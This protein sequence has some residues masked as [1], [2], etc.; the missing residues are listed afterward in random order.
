MPADTSRRGRAAKRSLVG[1]LAALALTGCTPAPAPSPTPSESTTPVR[2]FTVTTTERPATY[3]PAS[4]TTA[5]DALVAH[6]AFSRLMIVHA[7]PGELK[8]DLATDCLY[9]SATVYQCE[10]PKGLVFHN[11]HALTASDVKFSIERAYRLG[12]AGT[13]VSLLDSLQRVEVVD[14]QVVR[15]TLRW[16]DSQFG[17]ALASAAASIVDEEIY[18]PD[19]VRPN[20]AQT[21]GSGPYRLVTTADDQLVFERFDDYVGA[22]TATIDRVRL[23]FAADSAEVEALMAAESTDVV[24]RSLT[25]AAHERLAAETTATAD[26]LTKGGF[27]RQQLPAVR[28]QRLLWHPGS[29]ARDSAELRQVVALALQADRTMTSLI[30]SITTGAVDAFPTGGQPEVPQLGGQRLKLTLAYESRAPGQADLARLV[31]DRIESQAGV[32]VQLLPD[33][34]D[35][36]LFLSDRPAWVNTPFGWLQPY[37]DNALPG[38]ADKIAD[39]VRRARETTDADQRVA[40]LGEI[41]QQAAA[42]LTVLPIAQGAESLYLGRGVTLQGDPFGPGYQ[43]GLWSF[44]R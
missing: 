43:L 38:S 5:A 8:P 20:D 22:D 36:D 37:T 40:L 27:L 39:L 42:D 29:A 25:A 13:S 24:W 14:D 23:G 33:A 12:V 26:G 41:Q 31:R 34:P 4:A 7:A 30:P 17:Y 2:P 19:A 35:A 10:L 6:N 21:I 1:V 28:V 15:F 32:S 16:A 44:R 11:G 3:D 18:D 9:T